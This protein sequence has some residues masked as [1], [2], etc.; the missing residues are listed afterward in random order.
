MTLRK[1]LENRKLMFLLFL[2]FFFHSF[3][4][5][6]RNIKLQY[7]YLN[8][9]ETLISA[10]IQ[11]GT[12]QECSCK[13]ADS[14]HLD[15]NSKG[16]L[17]DSLKYRR[18]NAGPMTTTSFSS[19]YFLSEIPSGT[20]DLERTSFQVYFQLPHALPSMINIYEDL[21]LHDNTKLNLL[22]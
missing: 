16:N 14:I 1:P 17:N 7:A 2:S 9:K 22:H 6:P 18:V 19:L 11:K 20:Q 21:V 10:S 4:T 13:V 8:W 15:K 5:F 12:T 3:Q